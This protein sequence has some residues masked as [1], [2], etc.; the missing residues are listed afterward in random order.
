MPKANPAPANPAP[1]VTI[2]GGGI[3]GLAAALRLAERGFAV[4]ILEKAPLLGGNLSAVE[5]NG[6]PYDVY[7]HMFAEWY[8][9][10]W[11]LASDIGLKRKE[12]FEERRD[13]AFLRAN[14]FGNYH[15]C[16]DIGSLRAGVK[17]MLSGIMSPPEMFLANYTI[18][19]AISHS[20]NNDDY[21][22]NQTLNDFI[23]NRAYSTP[24]VTEFF[25]QAVSNIWSINSYLSSA[26][27][28]KRFAEY[29]FR[30]PSPLCWVLKG[31]AYNNLVI[32][33]RA[34]LEKLG[35]QIKPNTEVTG[36]TARD[37]KVAAISYQRLAY[38]KSGLVV[39]KQLEAPPEPVDNLIFATSPATLG[40][41]VFSTAEGAA[42][43]DPK[44]KSIVSLLPNLANLRRLGSDPLPVLY[45]AFNGKMANI[46]NYYVALLY[47]KYSLTFVKIDEL[48]GDKKTVLAVA[49]SDFDAI[50][51]KY[52]VDRALERANQQHKSWSTALSDD[53]E[54]VHA[55]RLILTEFQRY[56]RFEMDSDVDWHNTFFQPNLDQRLFI[57]QVGSEHWYTQVNYPEIENLYFAGSTTKN[58]I[59]I[60]TVEAS[61][62]SG[63]DAARALVERYRKTLDLKP[64]PIVVPVGYPTPALLAWKIMLAPYAALAKLWVDAD[65]FRAAT[66]TMDY[67][68]GA[69]AGSRAVSNLGRGAE[70]AIAEWWR[71]AEACYRQ[72]SRYGAPT[73]R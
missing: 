8:H 42:G 62:Y 38:D 30:E 52:A 7:P 53:P 54:L 31:N 36:V 56:V 3:A 18:L 51:I 29:Q 25:D 68:K 70:S 32:P 5:R 24:A 20:D 26:L 50:P 59:M 41:L 43:P 27:A 66:M 44:A 49:A 6:I 40:N 34:R 1:K 45:V 28:Y 14:D 57:N 4:T 15:V 58:P 64:V 9:N 63:L 69:K 71:M 19:D 33:L 12:H 61:V 46:P 22:Q 47:S 35:C 65:A 72:I 10:F 67:R 23:V 16:T 73:D 48:S 2:V 13:C 60:A 11:S 21:L 55:A 39:T 37:G 17:N